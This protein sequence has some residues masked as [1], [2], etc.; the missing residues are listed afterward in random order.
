MTPLSRRVD[1]LDIGDIFLAEWK[2]ETDGLF[3]VHTPDVVS[4]PERFARD[5]RTPPSASG[6]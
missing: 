4:D 2:Y 6:S 5:P 1:G 3:V